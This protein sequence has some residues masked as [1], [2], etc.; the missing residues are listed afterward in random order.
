LRRFRSS[1]LFLRDFFGWD[2]VESFGI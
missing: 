1:W 2:Q